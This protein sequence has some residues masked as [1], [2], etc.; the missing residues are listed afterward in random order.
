VRHL[1]LAA[2]LILGADVA[3]APVPKELKRRPDV[4]RMQG[5]WIIQPSLRWYFKGD[6]LYSGGTD[7]AGNLGTEYGIVLRSE[8]APAQMD[9]LQNGRIICTGIYK[10]EGESLHITYVHSGE[11]PKDFAPAPGRSIHVLLPSPEAK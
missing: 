8:L 5:V 10:F 11:R 4:E 6:K 9:I 7:T 2:V 1:A 3:S